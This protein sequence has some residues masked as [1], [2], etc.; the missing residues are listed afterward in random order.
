LRLLERIRSAVPDIFLRSTFIVGFPGESEAEWRQSM[1]LLSRLDFSHM[2]I[3]SYSPR[4]GT[5]AAALSG[6]VDEETKRRRSSELHEL[7]STMKRTALQR[8][9]GS[10]AEVLVEN[11]VSDDDGDCYVGYTPNY[12]RVHF[13]L[14]R[15]GPPLENSIVSVGI[16]AAE[17]HTGHLSGRAVEPR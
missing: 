15:N 3:F 5:K 11:R 8:A 2:H 6:Q 4:P 13:P 7:A 1:A 14:P 12:L 17:P 16:D 10:T 9:V